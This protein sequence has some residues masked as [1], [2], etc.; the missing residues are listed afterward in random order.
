MGA[1]SVFLVARKFVELKFN[2]RP[3]LVTRHR[4]NSST[5]IKKIDLNFA[6]FVDNCQWVVSHKLI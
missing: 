4:K 2:K 6:P 3:L 5:K 1:K